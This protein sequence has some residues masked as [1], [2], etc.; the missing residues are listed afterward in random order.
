M[1]ANGKVVTDYKYTFVG[2]TT[3][4]S[5]SAAGGMYTFNVLVVKDDGDKYGVVDLEGRE[6]APCGSFAAVGEEFDNG[7]IL[8]Q[9]SEGGKWS[10]M[11]PGGKIVSDL[12]FDRTFGMDYDD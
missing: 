2:E 11:D 6:I 8:V 3:P 7:L 1:D 12:V 4:G 5:D 10:L 9:E